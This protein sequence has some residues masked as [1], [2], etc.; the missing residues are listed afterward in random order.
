MVGTRSVARRPFLTR[1][2]TSICRRERAGGRAARLGLD[3]V[4]LDLLAEGVAVDAEVL[5]GP[6]EVAAVAL[7][8][9]HDELL[10]ELP[11]GLGEQDPLVH[12]LDD[13]GL[14]LLLH[15]TRPLMPRAEARTSRL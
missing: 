5:R 13:Q 4:L 8:H 7:Q 11:L 1:R 9:A 15:D 14:Q 2:R 12:H 10:L 3:L 6:R